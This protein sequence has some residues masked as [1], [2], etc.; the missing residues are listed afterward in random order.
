ML[1]LDVAVGKTPGEPAGSLVSVG[2][3]NR[4]LVRRT[5][6]PRRE[7]TV[8]GGSE[9]HLRKRAALFLRRLFPTASDEC[10]CGA[11]QKARWQ[12]PASRRVGWPGAS[13]PPAPT[14]P[15]VTVSPSPGS[16]DQPWYV[17][18]RRQWANS[19]GCLASS[20]AHLVTGHGLEPGAYLCAFIARP[21]A[22]HVSRNLRRSCRAAPPRDA[23][24]SVY[25]NAAGGATTS[26][27]YG[28]S[29][30]GARS[31][32]TGSRTCPGAG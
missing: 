14:D 17:R 27:T 25:G 8:H 24:V 30:R 11:K 16:S 1:L 2:S 13:Q 32:G 31:I 10:E 9:V 29:R 22:W 12:T 6:P 15:G 26:L 4:H 5:Q 23:I 3:E 7:R 19:P 28:A 18:T 20:P 21:C